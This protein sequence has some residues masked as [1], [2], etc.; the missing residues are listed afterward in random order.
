[1]MKRTEGKIRKACDIYRMISEG[2]RV[3]VA[4]SGGK[5]S[6]ALLA[7]LAALRR[8]YDKRFSLAAFTVDPCFDGQETDYGAIS[9]LCEQYGVEHHVKRT[10]MGEVVFDIRKEKNPCS[11]YA[12]ACG[13]ARCTSCALRMAATRSR[14]VTTWTTRS[15]RFFLTFFT[16]GD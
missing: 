16:R 4:V 7:G 14:L 15:K 11:F 3:A 12:P 10:N 1:M 8:Y 6:V 5:D 9:R 2:D 13:A